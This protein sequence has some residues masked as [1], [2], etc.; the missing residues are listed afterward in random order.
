MWPANFR[1]L[2]DGELQIPMPWHCIPGGVS[3]P[4]T[5]LVDDKR[6]QVVVLAAVNLRQYCPC[7]NMLMKI[8]AAVIAPRGHP[9]CVHHA[10]SRLRSRHRDDSGPPDLPL[11]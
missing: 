5:M 11:G 1:V 7:G 4:F 6:C 8:I 2:L 3:S 9:L 10:H